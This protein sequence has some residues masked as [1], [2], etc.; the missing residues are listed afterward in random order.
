MPELPS[1]AACC[2]VHEGGHVV[3]AD[4]LGVEP[5]A[6]NVDPADGRAGLARFDGKLEGIVGATVLAAGRIAERRLL[7]LAGRGP[8][9]TT[10]APRPS[11]RR[12][13][14]DAS[15]SKRIPSDEEQ[16]RALV[17]PAR[18]AFAERQAGMIVEQRWGRVQAIAGALLKRGALDRQELRAL[19]DAE[20][21]GPARV[22]WDGS[23]STSGWLYGAEPPAWADEAEP[24]SRA[25]K[26]PGRIPLEGRELH[27][28]PAI[29]S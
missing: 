14:V 23:A 15:T 29:Y 10:K 22:V 17:D 12:R 5:I 28:R 26:M 13:C 9:P 11:S 3:V 8:G 16:L 2:A 27:G 6:A 7:L 1:E 25:A 21:A 4:F 18:R 24:P 19:L 20:S